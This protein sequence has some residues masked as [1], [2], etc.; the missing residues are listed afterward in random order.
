MDT[1]GYC[2]HYNIDVLK[3][4]TDLIAEGAIAAALGLAAA[5][6]EMDIN[7][8]VILIGTPAEESG[9]G[10]FAFVHRIHH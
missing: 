4:S 10:V 5:M 3:V 2:I 8:K 1:V 6:R 9:G 7:G